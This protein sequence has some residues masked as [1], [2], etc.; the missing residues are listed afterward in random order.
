MQETGKIQSSLTTNSDS[1]KGTITKMTTFIFS[2]VIIFYIIF[3][4][5]F[6]Q[7]TSFGSINQLVNSFSTPLAAFLTISYFYTYKYLDETPYFYIALGWLINACYLPLELLVKSPC[8]IDTAKE[9]NNSTVS[10]HCFDYRISLFIFNLIT[11]VLFLYAA[12]LFSRLN[13][14]EFINYYDPFRKFNRIIIRYLS[15][16]LL[17]INVFLIIFSLNIVT[18]FRNADGEYISSRFAI[19]SVFGALFSMYAFIYLGYIFH[20][21]IN[22]W[23]LPENKD[24]HANLRLLKY[25]PYTFYLYGAIQISSPLKLYLYSYFPSLYYSLF[26]LGTTFKF[27]NLVCLVIWLNNQL[28]ESY[29]HQRKNIELSKVIAEEKLK[30]VETKQAKFLL[31]KEVEEKRRIEAELEKINIELQK[32]LEKM[33]QLASLGAVVSSIEHDIQIP[34]TNLESNIRQLK[35]KAKEDSRMG[36]KINSLLKRIEANKN[37]ISA[38]AQIISFVRAKEDFFKKNGFMSRVSVQK[39]LNDAIKDVKTGLNLDTKKYYFHHNLEKRDFSIYAYEEMIFQI[40]I[41]L[42]KNSYEALLEKGENKGEITIN[43]NQ[44][45]DFPES[46]SEY[47]EENYPKQIMFEKW[48]Q[49]DISDKGCGIPDSI[50]DQIT[51]VFTTKEKANGGIGLFIAKRVLDIHNSIIYFQSNAGEGT[52]VSLFLPEYSIYKEYLEKE[53]EKGKKDIGKNKSN[54][55]ILENLKINGI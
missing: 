52:T 13:R 19:S 9:S 38:S 15:P 7:Y 5:Y 2:L 51:D 36:E 27:V 45:K 40:L 18:F 17:I 22:I 55:E 33:T 26:F 12:I 28:T 35:K 21:S 1:S 29:E 46:M 8:T 39:V 54:E 14:S 10:S 50:I 49:I 44:I 53:I 11:P 32:E 23:F 43:V 31:E 24:D 41:N 25:F 34:V 3:F 30:E 6:N 20:K 16:P 37:R 47:L 48:I 42:F 4:S